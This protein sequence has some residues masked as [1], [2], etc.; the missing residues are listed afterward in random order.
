[1]AKSAYFL[2]FGKK[3]VRI[4]TYSI[5]LSQ[6]FDM[7]DVFFMQ[8][9]LKEAQKAFMKDEVPIGAVVVHKG[10]IISYGH[11]LVE[12]KQDASFHAE[13]VALRSAAEI[14]GNWRLEECTLYSTLEPCP[15]CAGAMYL[16]RVK[17]LVWGAPDL[18][19]G[20]GSIFNLFSVK[21]PI[22]QMT[23]S[24]GILKEDCATLLQK[25]FQQKR[26]RSDG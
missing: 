25:F 17:R 20:A 26:R 10:K 4:S 21:H 16:F 23:I 14:L 9:A 8:E 12:T 1:M 2:S 22:H 11:N 3:G 13:M 6:L 7:E 24:G 18:R 19:H 5:T 15:M